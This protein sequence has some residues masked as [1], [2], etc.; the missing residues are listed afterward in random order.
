MALCHS[1]GKAAC[2]PPAMIHVLRG[3][4]CEGQRWRETRWRP[5]L[6]SYQGPTLR[7]AA[8]RLAS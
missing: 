3:S 4:L 6:S 1:S 5:G 8:S 7:I 2:M